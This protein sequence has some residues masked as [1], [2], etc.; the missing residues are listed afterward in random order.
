M[1]MNFPT[2]IR[3]T[4]S[5]PLLPSQEQQS[6]S[7]DLK[8]VVLRIQTREW[9]ESKYK[10]RFKFIKNHSNSPQLRGEVTEGERKKSAGKLEAGDR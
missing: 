2:E 5:F 4:H 3:R 6:T 9:P 8:D 10:K 1:T 7:K